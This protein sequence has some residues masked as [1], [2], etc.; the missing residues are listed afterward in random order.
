MRDRDTEG[1]KTLQKEEDPGETKE[2]EEEKQQQ[3]EKENT[4]RLD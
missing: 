1:E 3:K 2:I 4:K